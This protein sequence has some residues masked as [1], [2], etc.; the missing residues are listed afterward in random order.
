MDKGGT[1]INPAVIA[2]LLGQERG[3]IALDLYSGG[4]ALDAL[5]AAVGDM[6]HC[7][8]DPEVVEALAETMDD[9]PRM[10][11]FAPVGAEKAAA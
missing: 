5:K 7:G 4:A 6:E 9:R 3:T 11:R 1:R 8:L 2:S 10:A